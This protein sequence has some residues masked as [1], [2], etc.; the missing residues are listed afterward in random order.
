[1]YL[2]I[3]DQFSCS[4]VCRASLF[5]Y[6]KNINESAVP[7]QTCFHHVKAYL[8]ENGVPYA[9][10]CV[11]LSVNSLVL[12]ILS[13]GFLRKEDHSSFEND[14]EHHG[15]GIAE[16]V[17]METHLDETR[18]QHQ[19]PNHPTSSSASHADLSGTDTDI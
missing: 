1:M 3:E 9:T 5:Y 13:L 12:A 16:P 8:M 14:S 7:N 15:A 6:G 11:L 10:C 4:G 18:R 2:E 19:G 17:A